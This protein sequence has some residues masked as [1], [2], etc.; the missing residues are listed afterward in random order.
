M[1]K[2]V[3]FAKSLMFEPI[4]SS[5]LSLIKIKNSRGPSIEPWGPLPLLICNSKS[6]RQVQ[7]SEPA[8][9]R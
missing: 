2:E 5:I 3:S 4:S 1:Y 6:Y 8:P 9:S 7:L